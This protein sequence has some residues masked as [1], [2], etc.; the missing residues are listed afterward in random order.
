MNDVLTEFQNAFNQDDRKEAAR[1]KW[2]PARNNPTAET[3]LD[4][5][6]R[7][8][9]IVKKAFQD[10]TGQKKPLLSLRQAPDLCLAGYIE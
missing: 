7:L 1:Y 10:N 2:N 5:L 9:V 3:F 6:N 4:F 8:K